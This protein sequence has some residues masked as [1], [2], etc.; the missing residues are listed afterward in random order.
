MRAAVLFLGLSLIFF[1]TRS[2][3][4]GIEILANESM[5]FSGLVDGKPAGMVIDILTAVTRDG[6]PA[7]NFDF[8]TPWPRAQ[9][10]VLDQTDLAIVPLTRTP[11]RE[12]D[13]QWLAELF[14]YRGH[15]VTIARRAPLKTIAEAKVLEVGVLKASG[16]LPTV[17]ALGLTR[18]QLAASDDVNA[19]RMLL[20]RLG[21][22]AAPEYVDRYTFERAGGDPSKLQYGPA[23]GDEF[24]L[25]VAA[26]P[27]FP[28]T[29]AKAIADGIG[30]LRAKGDIEKI[31]ER[32]R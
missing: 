2:Q 30:R 13:Y 26:S 8:S 1:A 20:G 10:L 19:Q 24:R 12:P 18:L 25:Y 5:P 16:L 21:A 32:Y 28:A 9:V 29:D 3:A 23:L 27:K 15:L 22:W 14:S 7:F 6:G 31:L 17:L 11:D 4:D